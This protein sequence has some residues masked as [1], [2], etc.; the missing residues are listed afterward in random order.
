MFILI[1]DWCLNLLFQLLIEFEA[2]LRRYRNASTSFPVTIND[3]SLKG[4]FSQVITW[5]VLKELV[6]LRSKIHVSGILISISV[7]ELVTLIHT[8]Q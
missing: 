2:L 7:K 8:I 5:T 1:L 6:L 4:N 3:S